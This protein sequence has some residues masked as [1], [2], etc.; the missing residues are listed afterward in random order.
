MEAEAGCEIPSVTPSIVGG[1]GRGKVRLLTR[2]DLDG[3]TKARRQF[4]AIAEGIAADLGG[5]DQLSTV[6]SAKARKPKTNSVSL[7]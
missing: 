4:D 3:R 1:N 6:Q 2:E 7:P 5:S